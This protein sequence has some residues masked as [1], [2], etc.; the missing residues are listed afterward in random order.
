MSDITLIGLGSMGSA[1]GRALL[2][3]GRSLTVWNRSPA[4]MATLHSFG[5]V[6]AS[7]A[8]HA[9]A[10]SPVTVMCI[11]DYAATRALMETPEVTARLPGSTIVQLS[12][13]TPGEA[14]EAEAYFHGRGAAYL[15]GA[16]MEFPERIGLADTMI[17]FSGGQD[18]W[19]SCRRTIEP[20]G[21]DL[22]YLGTAAGAAAALDLA[23]LTRTLAM[24]LGVAHGA[25][26]CIAES[27]D[28]TNYAAALVDGAD[29]RSFAET[30]ATGNFANPSATMNV[31]RHSLQRIRNHASD[32]AIGS[33]VPDFIEDIF[34]RAVA[35]GHGEHH[36]AALIKG[37]AAD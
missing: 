6:P 32:T 10:A 8:A 3:G 9:I 17:L 15:D 37:L 2:K 1:L 14:R 7:S 23:L 21:G 22:R 27:V 31:W 33:D 29:S 35:R 19:Q 13:G 30:M 11:A 25:R 5:A 20:L 26:I 4:R 34:A 28:L 18:A 12:T 16:I 36:V 24:A